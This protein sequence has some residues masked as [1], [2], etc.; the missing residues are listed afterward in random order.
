MINGVK[1]LLLRVLEDMRAAGSSRPFGAG[2]IKNG[3]YK[4]DD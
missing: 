1:S 4:S 2:I 3:S